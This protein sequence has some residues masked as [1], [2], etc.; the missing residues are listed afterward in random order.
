MAQANA[1]SALENIFKTP[2]LWE[3]ITFTLL[4]LLIY[5]VGSHVTA[6][7]VDVQAIRRLLVADRTAAVCSGCTTCS[8]AA[9]SRARRF[10]RWASCRTSRRRIFTQIARR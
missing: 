7:G 2:E 4:C 6:P 8:S 5:R 3:K 1:A 9:T 10:S